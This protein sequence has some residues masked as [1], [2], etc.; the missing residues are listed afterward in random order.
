[1]FECPRRIFH[2]SWKK[3][4]CTSKRGRMG[5]IPSNVTHMRPVQIWVK[6]RQNLPVTSRVVNPYVLRGLTL[7]TL[8]SDTW[9]TF[10]KTINAVVVSSQYQVMYKW[11]TVWT[12]DNFIASTNKL[13]SLIKMT[14]WQAHVVHMVKHMNMAGVP[15]WWGAL[16]P[17][18]FAPPLNP[19]LGWIVILNYA[20]Y[21][22]RS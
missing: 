6:Q 8:D 13:S 11:N 12:T 3:W 17:G 19:A 2:F 22:H 16:I 14:K 9:P 5:A 15:F 10:R 21:V 1:M 7:E 4:T 18:P 20:L